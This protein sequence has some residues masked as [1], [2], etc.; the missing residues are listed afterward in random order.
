MSCV[1]G[2]LSLRTLAQAPVVCS[3]YKTIVLPFLSVEGNQIIVGFNY[4]HNCKL[5]RGIRT[6]WLSATPS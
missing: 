5:V 2:A 3:V 1:G 4:R 6:G